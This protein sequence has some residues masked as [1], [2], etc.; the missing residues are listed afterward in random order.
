MRKILGLLAVLAWLAAPARA[1]VTWSVINNSDCTG[2]GAA[3]GKTSAFVNCCTGSKLGFCNRRMNFGDLFETLVQLAASGTYT[4]GGDTVPAA[5]LAKF[6]F[7]ANIVFAQC[8]NALLG[9]PVTGLIIPTFMRNNSAANPVKIQLFEPTSV[10][11]SAA[12]GGTAVNSTVVGGISTL[13]SSGNAGTFYQN[14]AEYPSGSSA[15]NAV[16]QCLILGN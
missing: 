14:A 6:G 7:S 13:S 11:M 4:T 16:I 1:A 2:F 10:T 8:Q 3:T 5:E 15:S 12:A 9:S